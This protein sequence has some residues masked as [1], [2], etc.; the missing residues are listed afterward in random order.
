MADKKLT[1]DI[2]DT[3]SDESRTAWSERLDHVLRL[4]VMS[5]CVSMDDL[6]DLRDASEYFADRE[7]DRRNVHLPKRGGTLPAGC[8]LRT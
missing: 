6:R 8:K 5:L 4:L 1:D 2:C 7:R 3:I